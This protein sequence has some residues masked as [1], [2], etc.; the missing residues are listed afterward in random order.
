M[1][2][3]QIY[4]NQGGGISNAASL[5]VDN[6]QL[7]DN[8]NGA[9]RSTG[10]GSITINHSSIRD[11]TP[12]SGSGISVADSTL[13]L[14][15][16][17]IIG[18]KT[19]GLVISGGQTTINNS[20]ITDNSGD[21]GGGVYVTTNA[22]VTINNSTIAHN[23]ATTGGGIYIN[24]GSVTVRNSIIADNLAYSSPECSGALSSSGYN[25]FGNP[26][27]CT[28]SLG[29]GDLTNTDPLLGA[30]VDFSDYYHLLPGSPAIDAG[31]PALPGSG[32]NA[33]LLTDQRGVT[34]LGRCDIG[35]YEYTAPGPAASIT[36]LS[37]ADQRTAPDAAFWDPIRLVVL[38]ATGGP[39][40]NVPVTFTAPPSGP[41]AIFAG[42][43]SHTATVNADLSGFVSSPEFIANGISGDFAITASSGDP[44]VSV[45][46]DMVIGF[47]YYVKKAG[48]DALSC[49]TPAT[50]CATI[51]APLHK[52]GFEPGDTIKVATGIYTT[53]SGTEVLLLDGSAILSGGW[54]DAFAEQSGMSTVDGENS[55]WVVTVDSGQTV[56]IERFIVQHGYVNAN[57][58][59][60]INNLGTLSLKA[61]AIRDNIGYRGGGICNEGTLTVSDSQITGNQS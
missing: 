40:A 27:G 17:T 49:L 32:G 19:T 2:D 3:S 37:G 8:V 12:Y 59:A 38:D 26:A 57:N 35:A 51:A 44:A 50:A 13:T 11:N 41:S 25:L 18:M 31:N 45:S 43:G 10:P 7:Y 55:R 22:V 53:T 6:T 48:N 4:H 42:S 24:S 5:T 61:S 52:P 36:V 30:L 47:P 56:K 34:R 1:T 14:N 46:M 21:T 58:C 28:L 33:C 54:D 60:G 15:E 9:I 29:A 16:I 20:T 23:R 39:A